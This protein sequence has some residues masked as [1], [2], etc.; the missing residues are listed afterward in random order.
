[1]DFK[2]PLKSCF[3]AANGFDGFRSYFKKIF[4]PE[5]YSRTFVLKGGPGT[6]KSTLMKKVI[7]HFENMGATVEAVFCSS[8]PKSLDGIT[9]EF[10]NKKTAVLD[11][12]AP[13]ETDAK[14]PGAFDEIINLG[15]CWNTLLLSEERKRIFELNNRKTQHYLNAYKYLSLAGM[16]AKSIYSEIKNL[17]DYGKAKNAIDKLLSNDNIMYGRNYE[18]SLI[19]AFGKGGFIRLDKLHYERKNKF[20]LIGSYMSDYAFAEYIASLF[21]N[22]GINNT[23]FISPFSEHLYE[24]IVFADTVL[25]I[26]NDFEKVL[27]TT[28]FLNNSLLC[29]QKEKLDYFT[30]YKDELLALSQKEFAK[31]SDTHFELEKIYS[32]VMDFSAI[33]TVTA[34]LISKIEKIIYS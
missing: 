34:N 29:E 16:F 3:A 23:L 15:E 19:S 6:G 18:M 9:I 10:K 7:T 21:K 4:S 24:G 30:K 20:S 13:H 11:G 32:E 17:F 8:D 22:Y 33:D 2:A 28:D 31:A 5:A 25:L 12:T 26:G 14:M 1:M 27:D